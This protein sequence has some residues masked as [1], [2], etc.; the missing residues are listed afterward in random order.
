M[1]A[2][3]TPQYPPPYQTA[4]VLAWHLTVTPETVDRWVKDEI[5]PPPCPRKSSKG[6]RLWKWITVCQWLDGDKSDDGQSELD[7]FVEGARRAAQE[8]NRDGRSA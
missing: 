5:L 7:P 1:R 6:H 8:R 3:V 2:A 4:D